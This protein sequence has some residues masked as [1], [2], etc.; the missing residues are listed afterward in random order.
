MIKKSVPEKA[1]AVPAA[2]DGRIMHSDPRTEAILLTLKPGEKI[3]LH[4]NPFDVLFAG[5]EGE[6]TLISPTRIETIKPGET[7][8]ITADEERA[9]MNNGSEPA[10]VMVFKIL[11]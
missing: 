9:W 11:K 4:K 3:P 1:L 10:R 7:I 2:I 8:F 6:A 5:I